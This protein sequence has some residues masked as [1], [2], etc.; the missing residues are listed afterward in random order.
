[1]DVAHNLLP[2]RED[3]VRDP[4]SAFHAT[5]DLNEFAAAAGT[6]SGVLNVG[7]SEPSLGA[8]EGLLADIEQ[9]PA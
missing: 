1:M 6:L 4:P 2:V 8:V 5:P 9:H 3:V 7:S